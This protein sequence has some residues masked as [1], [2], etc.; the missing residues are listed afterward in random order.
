MIKARA[1]RFKG[2]PLF[3]EKGQA[4]ETPHSAEFFLQFLPTKPCSRPSRVRGKSP[5]SDA[6]MISPKLYLFICGFVFW[7]ISGFKDKELSMFWQYF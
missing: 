6:C 5:S 4:G 7:F 1:L 3:Y 2:L